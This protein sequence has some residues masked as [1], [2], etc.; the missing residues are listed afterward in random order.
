MSAQGMVP[1]NHAI[2]VST[3]STCCPAC[4]EY[5]SLNCCSLCLC[6][7]FTRASVT[8]PCVGA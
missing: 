1:S 2:L 6:W 3:M 8:L 7:T 4:S 5:M